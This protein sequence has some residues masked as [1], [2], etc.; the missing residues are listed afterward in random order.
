MENYSQVKKK[1][2]TSFLSNVKICIPIGS[3]RPNFKPDP[4]KKAQLQR[5]L[6][7]KLDEMQGQ[8]NKKPPK[9]KK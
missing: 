2:L 1:P 6:D 8:R 5:K 4:V 3:G 7:K 9:P